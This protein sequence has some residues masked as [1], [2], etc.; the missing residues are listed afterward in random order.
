MT[1]FLICKVWRKPLG[2]NDKLYEI[3]KNLLVNTIIHIDEYLQTKSSV[4][5]EFIGLIIYEDINDILVLMAQ[6]GN[7]E[8]G[9]MADAHPIYAFEV[10]SKITLCFEKLR[11]LRDYP[12][13]LTQRSFSKIIA[14][15][16]P[17]IFAPWFV[18]MSSFS[19]PPFQYLSVFYNF[20][21]SFIVNG[22]TL[23]S[24]RLFDPFVAISSDQIDL[25]Q[26]YTWLDNAIIRIEKRNY[27]L[28]NHTPSIPC[29]KDDNFIQ[30]TGTNADTSATKIP[31]KVKSER[32]KIRGT[33][34]YSIR[35]DRSEDA[36][37]S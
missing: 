36:P 33:Y 28:C 25:S 7:D 24:D 2:V 13:P 26:T 37:K 23:I 15:F 8:N 6:L 18:F 19:L 5:R 27:V 20:I 1:T 34:R 35:V 16:L 31:F 9:V 4:N 32:S 14:L 21:F 11:R 22:Q 30:D 12:S 29:G 3:I 17:L 10:A